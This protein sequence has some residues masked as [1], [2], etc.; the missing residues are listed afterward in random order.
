MALA[1]VR[2]YKHPKTGVYWLREVVPASLRPVVGRQEFKQ[3]LG[4]KDPAKARQ[5]TPPIV[6][7]WEGIISAARTGGSSLSQRDIEAIR[8]EW[9]RAEC[10]FWGDDP[11][12]PENWDLYLDH[13]Y[14]RWEHGDPDADP[15]QPTPAKL[16][17]GDREEAAALLEQHGQLA[18]TDTVTRLGEALLGAKLDFGREMMKRARGDWSP[19]ATLARFPSLNSKRPRDASDVTQKITTVETV[20]TA[21]AA[22]TGTTG[23]ALCDRE[24]T[25][26]LL[27]DFLGH[28]DANR[29]TADD[30]VRWKESRLAAGRSTKTVTNDIGELRPIWK[31]GKA[32]RK[33]TFVENPFAGLAPRTKRRGRGPRGP[34]TEAEAA[35]LL[36]AARA[37]TDASLR[38]LPWVLCFTGARLGEVTQAVKE[39][40]KREGAD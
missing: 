21:W 29:V 38:W 8:G 11:G 17:Q 30:I 35:K 32:N 28:H 7:R 22:E 33:L 10:A 9:Y 25:A 24:R 6:A 13:V 27:T 5:L 12:D 15:T 31:W 20:L 19:G 39:D 3:T 18:E 2:P 23:K 40:V 1:M 4:T 37:E 16:T 34:Y 26:S 14:S 36:T